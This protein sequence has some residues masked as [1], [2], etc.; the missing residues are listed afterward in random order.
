KDVIGTSAPKR[1]GVVLLMC[2]FETI[3]QGMGSDE[4]REGILKRICVLREDTWLGRGL[5]RAEFDTRASRERK[6][7]DF[8]ARNAKV[9]IRIR[10]QL[11]KRKTSEVEADLIDHGRGN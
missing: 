7:F 3:L 1:V 9:D 5:I 6:P 11:I 2:I 10:G 4:M 8:Y